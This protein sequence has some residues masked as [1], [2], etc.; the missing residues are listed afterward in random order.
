[1]YLVGFVLYVVL[2]GGVA[3]AL[4][5]TLTHRARA[6]WPR[7][8]AAGILAPIVF[9]LPLAD[10]IVGAYQFERLCEQAKDVKIYG[11]IPVGL[12][13]YT[14]DGKWRIGLQ[15]GE[16][17]QRLK[18]WDRAQ[19]ALDSHVR[20]DLGPTMPQEVPAAIPIRRYENK[21]FDA[22]TGRLLAE[23]R[24]YGTSGG[25]FGR[26]VVA[27]ELPLIVRPQCMPE[28]LARSEIHQSI[29]KFNRL[30]TTK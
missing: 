24:Q 28:I 11:T 30:E 3:W 20:W 22:K 15:E 29:L 1:M 14:P 5:V 26:V 12:E 6:R 7:W 21:I 8:V 27:G 25:W 16:L 13:L 23:W 19:K 10:E 4:G 18:D 9:F 2:C 17:E